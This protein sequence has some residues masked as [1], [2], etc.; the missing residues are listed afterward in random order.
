M[1]HE[2]GNS[3]GSDN[4]ILVAMHKNTVRDTYAANLAKQGLFLSRVSKLDMPPMLLVPL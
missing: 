2:I 1:Q 3:L 4:T